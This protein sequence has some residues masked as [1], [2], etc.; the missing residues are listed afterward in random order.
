MAMV[1]GQAGI[2]VARWCHGLSMTDG[3]GDRHCLKRVQDGPCPMTMQPL[4]WL[5]D[6]KQLW[7]LQQLLRVYMVHFCK[8]VTLPR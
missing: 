7:C 8:K 4:N 2:R 6:A 1:G 5:C 3:L